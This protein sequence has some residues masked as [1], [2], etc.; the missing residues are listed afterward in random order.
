MKTPSRQLA[1]IH[2]LVVDDDEDTRD[3]FQTFLGAVGAVVTTARNAAEG[4]AAL[5]S[6]KADVIVADLSMP[7]LDGYTVEMMKHLE[8]TPKTSDKKSM[9]SEMNS[10]LCSLRRT[11]AAM[12]R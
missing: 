8:R 4:I 12:T 2:V 6:M 7:G 3:I 9:S 10:M 1:G 11:G 5:R